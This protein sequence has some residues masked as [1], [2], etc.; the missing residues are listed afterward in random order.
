MEKQLVSV[1]I[2][3]RNEEKY[4]KKCINSVLAF[5]KPD[6]IEIEIIIVDGMSTD[7]TLN[8]LLSIQNKHNNVFI[9]KNAGIYQSFAINKALEIAKGRWIMRLDA[10]AT[11][12]KEYLRLCIETAERTG[13]DNLGGLINS[14][15]L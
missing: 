4:I 13:A 15:V 3:C 14:R 12:P 6:G 11:Y 10:H 2:P 7:D 5:D 1:V 9:L 8:I